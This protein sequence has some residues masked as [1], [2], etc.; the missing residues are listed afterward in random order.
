[1]TFLDN[2]VLKL[3]IFPHYNTFRIFQRTVDS[4]QPSL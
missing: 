1:M 2:K 4:S 3:R